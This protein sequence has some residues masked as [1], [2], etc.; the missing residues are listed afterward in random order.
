M[1]AG[2]PMLLRTTTKEKYTFQT[3]VRI[4]G[5]MDYELFDR[6]SNLELENIEFGIV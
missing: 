2:H 3:F 5:I 1:A 4:P 6:I